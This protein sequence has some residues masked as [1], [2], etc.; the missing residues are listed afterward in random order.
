[1]PSP[2]GGSVRVE[3]QLGVGS[4]SLDGKLVA[5]GVDVAPIRPYLPVRARIAGKAGAELTVKVALE[6]LAVAAQGK[7][8]LQD[9]AV[10]DGDRPLVTAARIETTGIDYAWPATAKI[11]RIEIQ[12]PTAVL[13]RR[14]DGTLPLGA[15][16]G[17]PG[18]AARDTAR[19]AVVP[20]PNPAAID[21]V[22][23]EVVVAGGSAVIVDGV[24]SP[25]ARA[26]LGDLRLTAKDV[27]WPARGPASI[28]L[29]AAL[30][31]GGTASAEG[32]SAPTRG[33]SI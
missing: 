18:V 5:S 26:E 25:P 32:A 19:Q 11:D 24:V 17:P 1:M 2:G 22:V 20:R 31:G 6:P 21:V 12:K 7:A 15:L 33:A 13:E 3:G 29:N 30:P 8:D 9:L 28:Q 10:A 27:T 14:A 23:R 16:L 4:R